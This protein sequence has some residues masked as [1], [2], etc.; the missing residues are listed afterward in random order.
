MNTRELR[1]LGFFL[2]SP[3]DSRAEEHRRMLTNRPV[4][5]IA[6]RYRS[7]ARAVSRSCAAGACK[8]L[9]WVVVSVVLGCGLG[10]LQ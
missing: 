6:G 2:I 7:A 9:V 1:D 10:Q 4:F 3:E 5:A 8:T